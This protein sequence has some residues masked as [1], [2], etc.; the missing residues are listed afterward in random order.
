MTAIPQTLYIV[1]NHVVRYPIH[2]EASLHTRNLKCSIIII[3]IKPQC[4]QGKTVYN[5][6]WTVTSC[7]LLPYKHT[8][9]T[10]EVLAEKYHF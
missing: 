7:E 5:L 8:F 6:Y 1:T 2:E 9:T 3:I 4:L 10:K